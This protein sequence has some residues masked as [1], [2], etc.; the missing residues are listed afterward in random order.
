MANNGGKRRGRVVDMSAGEPAHYKPP[1]CPPAVESNT[2]IEITDTDELRIRMQ[3]Y[4]DLITFFAIMQ[5]V[6]D[7][8]EW[9]EVARIDCCHS[10]IHRHQFVL[11]DGR[12]IHD[13]QL[14][15]EI[16]PDGGERWSVVNDGYHKALAVMYEEWETNVQRWRDGR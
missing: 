8:G 11:P 15:V 2:R 5:M 6:W 3:V 10:T 13:H 14:I 12:D 4:K 1:P 9:K 7:D 16:P